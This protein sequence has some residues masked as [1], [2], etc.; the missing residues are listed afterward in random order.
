MKYYW[1]ILLSLFCF[2]AFAQ[3]PDEEKQ[4]KQFYESIQKEVDKYETTLELEYWQVFYVDSILTHDYKAMR[5]EM[6]RYSAQ[7]VSSSD[8]YIAVQDKWMEQIYNSFRGIFTDEQWQ[9]Y[10]KQGAARE[11]KAR[12][13]R[14]EKKQ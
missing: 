11:K 1:T 13:K 8:A 4:E 14:A 12:D 7:K 9:K 10:L 2:A 3:N 5:E 6:M